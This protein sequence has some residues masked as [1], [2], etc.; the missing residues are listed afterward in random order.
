MTLECL[1]HKYFQQN[2]SLAYQRCTLQPWASM[3]F[4]SWEVLTFLDQL[5]QENSSIKGEAT[6]DAMRGVLILIP[7]QFAIKEGQVLV[8]AQAGDEGGRA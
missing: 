4:F 6:A 7:R 1:Y 8:Q 3:D 2:A 5:L